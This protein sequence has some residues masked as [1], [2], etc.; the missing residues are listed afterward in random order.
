MKELGIALGEIALMWL[1]IVATIR[2]FARLD[3]RAAW[4]LAPYLAW[5]TFA[6]TLNYALWTLN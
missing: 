2:A 6:A 4:L 1:A 3:R 5:V